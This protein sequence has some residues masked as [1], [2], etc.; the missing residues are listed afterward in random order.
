MFVYKG[1]CLIIPMS[2]TSI[3]VARGKNKAQGPHT[4]THNQTNKKQTKKHTS[5]QINK[6]TSGSCNTL[7]HMRGHGLRHAM[8]RRASRSHLLERTW[9]DTSCAARRTGHLQVN[10]AAELLS[11]CSRRSMCVA[12]QA[13]GKRTLCCHSE[14]IYTSILM[15]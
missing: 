13:K 9:S 14:L 11:V 3:L 6:Q 2:M 7:L 5:K 15:D 12:A 10:V 8:D 4:H 1:V